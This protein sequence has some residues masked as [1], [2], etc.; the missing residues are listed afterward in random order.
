MNIVNKLKLIITQGLPGSGKSTW[1]KYFL[2]KNDYNKWKRVS[3]D[4]IRMMLDCKPFDKRGEG[5]VDEIEM[6]T[7]AICLLEKYNIIIDSTNLGIGRLCRLADK[8]SE[9]EKL[10]KVPII[11]TVRKFM[12]VTVEECVLRDQN[13]KYPVGREII[14]KMYIDWEIQ[15]KRLDTINISV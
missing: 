15:R 1:V 3:R 11:I 9:I 4:S 14:E 5:L 8:V 10:V 13:R 12:E 2:H 7:I 6:N